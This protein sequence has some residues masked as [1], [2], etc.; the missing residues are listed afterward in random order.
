MR[1]IK[2]FVLSL[3][4]IILLAVAFILVGR[5]IFLLRASSDLKQASNYLPKNAL[6]SDCQDGFAISKN[7]W[8]QIRFIS[9]S[10]YNLEVVC[11]DFVQ[12]PIL[13]EAKKLP[14][15]V[16]KVAGSSGFEFSDKQKTQ[17]ITLESFGRQIHL[18]LETNQLKTSYLTPPD[19]DYEAGPA[20]S[21]SAFNYQCC[22]SDVQAGLGDSI[23]TA[24]DCPKSCYETCQSRP[25]I[26][27]LNALPVMDENKLVTL[28]SGQAV[29][30]SYVV[31]DG[32][33][34]IFS[35]QVMDGSLE[36][37]NKKPLGQILELL[38]VNNQADGAAKLPISINLDFG[39]GQGANSQKLK[40]KLEH[41]YTC[42]TATCYYEVKLTASDSLGVLAVS[43]ES[44]SLMVKVER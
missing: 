29:T 44:S 39:D 3:L 20:S 17:F 32:R 19:L 10:E 34:E 27:S 9:D 30:F 2:I 38:D 6:L 21:C 41:I 31:S 15:F 35:D 5:E 26:L 24:T 1:V 42:S 4:A 8:S 12:K 11:S 16:K 23:S 37:E 43:N 18:Y 36:D 40:D 13:K 22:Q 7:V 28:R 14:I 25:L 33:Q